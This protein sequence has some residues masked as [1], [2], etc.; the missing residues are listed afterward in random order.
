MINTHSILTYPANLEPQPRRA[1]RL[2]G[3][4]IIKKVMDVLNF[5]GVWTAEE[6]SQIIMVDVRSVSECL[7]NLENMN[8]IFIG[9]DK[10]N[11]P[12]YSLWKNY[13]STDMAT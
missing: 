5:G 7:F 12:T 11:K 1:N 13:I 6:I 2:P 8:R 3:I 4:K 10:N 9:H